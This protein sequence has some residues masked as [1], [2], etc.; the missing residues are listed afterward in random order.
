[1]KVKEIH[2]QEV[3]IHKRMK[4]QAFHTPQTLML[5]Q[6]WH[7]RVKEMEIRM[8]MWET[9]KTE[10]GKGFRLEHCRLEPGGSRI[11]QLPLLDM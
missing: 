8:T 10:Q 1:M 4:E 9:G 2:L 7:M 5:V 11:R 3:E 6:D